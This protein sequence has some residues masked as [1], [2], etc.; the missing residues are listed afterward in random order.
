M[1]LGVD[2][3]TPQSD[4]RA[5]GE[6][7]DPGTLVAYGQRA[8]TPSGC[9]ARLLRPPTR[10]NHKGAMT[11]DVAATSLAMEGL[12]RQLGSMD[13]RAI[14]VVARARNHRNQTG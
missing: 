14:S 11:P 8:P 9:V 10:R 4:E 13:R 1:T 7:F 2:S 5:S 12:E 3:V 6:S